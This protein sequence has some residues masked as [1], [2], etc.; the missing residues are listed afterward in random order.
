MGRI[1]DFKPRAPFSEKLVWADVE[2]FR[3]NYREGA[4]GSPVYT[5]A[6]DKPKLLGVVT[7]QWGAGPRLLVPKFLNSILTHCAQL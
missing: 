3:D 7:S 2:F 5:V 4:S 1:A 6:G